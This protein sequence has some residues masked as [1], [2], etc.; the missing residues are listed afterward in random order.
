MI[1]QAHLRVERR[2]ERFRI[3]Y[4]APGA[5]GDNLSLLEHD[6]M[7]KGRCDLLNMMCHK[8]NRWRAFRSSQ[9]LE[10]LQK[11]FTRHRVKTRAWFVE[12]Q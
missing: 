12:D 9:S 7:R 3:Q 5:C 10:E 6:E 2:R 11:M 1:G 4:I 8:D